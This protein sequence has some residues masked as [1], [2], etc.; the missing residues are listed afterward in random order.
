MSIPVTRPAPTFTLSEALRY[1]LSDK[2]TY[3][4]TLP[5]WQLAVAHGSGNGVEPP[6]TVTN[7]LVGHYSPA[8]REQLEK[9]TKRRVD[10]TLNN[11]E[12]RINQITTNRQALQER[13]PKI[14]SP[15]TGIQYP[16]RAAV[17]RVRELDEKINADENDGLRHH[18]RV[19]RWVRIA[20]RI[21][22]YLEAV[23]LALFAATAL[24]VDFF[25]PFDNP[26]GWSLA[27][28]IVVVVLY[29]Q[30]RFVH[31]SAEA[32]NHRREANA[33]RQSGAAEQATKRVTTNTLIAAA[34][35]L[36]VTGALVERFVSV[37]FSSDPAI[38]SLMIGLSVLAGIGMPAL[39]WIATAWDGSSQS[40][41]RDHL[42][43]ELDHGLDEDTGLRAAANLLHEQ[44]QADTATLTEHTI[45]AIIREADTALDPARH[46]Y[47]F[48]RI[49]L[50]G[51]PD[52]PP[53]NRCDVPATDPWVLDSTIPGAELI[54]LTAIADRIKRLNAMTAKQDNEINIINN[55]P[56]HPWHN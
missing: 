49:Q 16:E 10:P 50:G 22:P 4:V 42:A 31:A 2:D 47:A 21:M 51:L 13:D 11:I 37:N 17:V 46:A 53:Y 7:R 41:E 43:A 1:K 9:I 56:T 34:F 32:W 5:L 29:A 23:G 15:E 52:A 28:V 54:K 12:G 26:F 18:R 45:P 24:N 14:T 35:A 8:V 40:R 38:I 44:N 27:V 39:A 30:P 6:S 19:A 20:G 36:F 48:L 33:D 3:K 55:H 25:D